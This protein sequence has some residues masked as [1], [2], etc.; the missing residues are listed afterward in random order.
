MAHWAC[1]VKLS[2]DLPRQK[3]R[4]KEYSLRGTG[5]KRHENEPVLLFALPVSA[6][7]IPTVRSLLLTPRLALVQPRTIQNEVTFLIPG[8]SSQQHQPSATALAEP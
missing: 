1:F 8:L 4:K 7:P 3:H 5:K 6:F 2:W